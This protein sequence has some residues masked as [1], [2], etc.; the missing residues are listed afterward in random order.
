MTFLSCTTLSNKKFSSA[1]IPRVQTIHPGEVVYWSQPIPWVK[2]ARLLCNGKTFIH[3]HDGEILSAYLSESYFTH[4]KPIECTYGKQVVAK[5][6]VK[7]KK[8]PEEELKVFRK[9]V[10]LSPK[11]QA[12]AAR[13]WKFLKKIYDNGVKPPLFE[14]SFETPIKSV[15]TSIYG[16]RRT[17]NNIRKSQ[18]LGTDF[19]AR[20]GTPV[21]A[22]ND[23]KVVVAR[24]LFYSGKTIVLDHGMGIFTVYGHL[25]KLNLAEKSIVAKNDVIGLSGKTGRITGPHLHWGVKVNGNYVDG[26]YLVKIG[27]NSLASS[28]S[29]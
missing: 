2:G 17:F 5:F 18:H 26:H 12:R 7:D 23:G 11:D 13:E 25:S 6:S 19:R 1:K 22:S 15:I 29:K 21:R 28:K 16:T 4:F 3:H 20:V 14:D 10:V 8:F 27:N 9:K 24:D